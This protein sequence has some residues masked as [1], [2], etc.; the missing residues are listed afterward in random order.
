MGHMGVLN[1]EQW[2]TGS[3]CNFTP[4]YNRWSC[5]VFSVRIMDPVFSVHMAVFLGDTQRKGTVNFIPKC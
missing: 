5:V 2:G 4:R 3:P 1:S